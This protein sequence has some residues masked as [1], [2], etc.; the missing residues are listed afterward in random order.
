MSSPHLSGKGSSVTRKEAVLGFPVRKA[1][2]PAGLSGREI[3]VDKKN[4]TSGIA[5]YLSVGKVASLTMVR[6]EML[7]FFLRL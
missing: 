2:S 1:N 4:K 5:M 7:L 3:R 6:G